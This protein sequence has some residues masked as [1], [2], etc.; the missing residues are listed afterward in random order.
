MI[1]T[2]IKSRRSTT[3]GGLLGLGLLLACSA[4]EPA[5]PAQTTNPAAEGGSSA[6]LAG[7]SGEVPGGGSQDVQGGQAGSSPAPAPLLGTAPC[8]A[9]LAT[10]CSAARDACR[11]DADCVICVNEGDDDACHRTDAT[12][13]RADAVLT[14]RG[15]ACRKQCIGETTPEASCAGKI[16][17]DCGTCLESACCDETAACFDNPHC[18]AC[19]RSGDESVCHADAGGHALFH[20]LGACVSKQCA[21]DCQ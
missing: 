20:A 1:F 17:G 21:S 16:A 14:C 5:T 19:V 4:D 13:E 15:A 10:T 2:F 8:D 3:F 6:G 11:D 9:C 7:S 18:D 12:H